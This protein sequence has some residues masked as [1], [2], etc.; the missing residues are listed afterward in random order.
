MSSTLQIER[1]LLGPAATAGKALTAIPEDQWFDRK[2]FR[3]APRELANVMVGFANADG[4]TLVVGIHDSKVEGTDG[5]TTHRNELMQAHVQHCQPP[6][7]A[8]SWLLPC[9]RDDDAPDHLLIVDI[10]PGDTVYT[11]ARDEVFLRVGDEN[12]RLTYA[13]RQELLYDRGQGSYEARIVEGTSSEALDELLLEDYARAVGHP[14]A[15]R[16]LQARGLAVDRTLTVAGTLLF[17]ETPQRFLPESFIRVLRYRGDERGSGAR[18]QLIRDERIEGPIAHQ[19]VRAREI[20]A[21]EQPR[22]RALTPGGTFDAVPLIPEDAWLEGLVNAVVHRSY[23]L[24]G[25]HIRVEIFSNRIEVSS[26]GRFP[27]LIDSADPLRATRYA[28][29]P[30]IA[31]VCADQNFGQELGEGIRRMFEEMRLAGL[32]APLYEETPASVKLL[33]LAEPVDRD[34]EARL[35]RDARAIVA[36]IRGAGRLSTGDI[37]EMLGISRPTASRHL[38]VLRDAELVVWSGKSPK[39][40]RASWSLPPT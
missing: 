36:A 6:V 37:A 38:R 32:G 8:R 12:R 5:S 21:Q 17:A 39:D 24:A 16:L 35:P 28:R 33:L 9:R 19:L 20:V 13:Q 14:D 11:N 40:P 30:R 1:A 18:Q 25:D 7:P 23:S 27:G 34:M 22:R 29:N 15:I 4:G 31:R 10:R 2:S 3:V 26:P